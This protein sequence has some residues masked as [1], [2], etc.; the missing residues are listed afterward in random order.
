MRSDCLKDVENQR[1]IFRREI[2]A[3]KFLENENST[4]TPM[5]LTKTLTKLEKPNEPLIYYVGGIDLLCQL[6]NDGE[7]NSSETSI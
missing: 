5:N 3:K 6:I 2:S 4:E 7:K 1:E